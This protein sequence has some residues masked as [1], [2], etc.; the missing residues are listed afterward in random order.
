MAEFPLIVDKAM[1]A[2]QIALDKLQ[3]V[4]KGIDAE[5]IQVSDSKGL[6][7][8]SNSLAGTARIIADLE[9][10]SRERETLIYETGEL[11]K[12]ELRHLLGQQPE[13][14]EEIYQLLNKA[15]DRLQL[16]E[17]TIKRKR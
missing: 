8:I 6:Y 11:L 10:A 9:R 1:E 5:T 12:A 15:E 7:N 17:E 2:A 4:L 3:T 13:L 16:P 14:L